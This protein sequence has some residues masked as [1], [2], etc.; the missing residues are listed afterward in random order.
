MHWLRMPR[1]NVGDN[2][3]SDVNRSCVRTHE[4]AQMTDPSTSQT[5]TE[6]QP[7]TGEVEGLIRPED[8]HST[9]RS[10]LAIILISIG[11]ILLLC[12]FVVVQTWVR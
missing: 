8:I 11:I 5:Q 12:V 1:T 3:G 2:T 4:K 10:C 9:S 7:Q 6:E